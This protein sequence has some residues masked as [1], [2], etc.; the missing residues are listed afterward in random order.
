MITP[1][2]QRKSRTVDYC[3][4]PEVCNQMQKG[5]WKQIFPTV[6]FDKML[7]TEHIRQ[8]KPG[9]IYTRNLT[10]QSARQE[11]I[12]IPELINSLKLLLYTDHLS[13]L[14]NRCCYSNH[15]HFVIFFIF[16]LS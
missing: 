5:N 4:C 8:F 6:S 14:L 9:I 7:N 2:K 16:C 12:R 1:S 13:I 3:S 15:A 11:Y 10:L